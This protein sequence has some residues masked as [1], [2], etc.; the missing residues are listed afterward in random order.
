LNVTHQLLV[1]ADDVNILGGSVHTTKKNAETLVDASMETG[2]EVHA[3]RT[4]YMVMFRDQNVGRSHNLMIDN[5]SFGRMEEL[6]YLGT[7]L[8]NQYCIQENI[9]SRFKSGNACCHL[10]QDLLS[11]SLLSKNLK[12][13]IYRAIILPV[14]FNGRETW[15]LTLREESRLR[16]LRRIFGPKR[17]EVTTITSKYLPVLTQYCWGDKLRRMKCEEHVAR[18]GKRYGYTGFWWGNLRER[19]HMGGPGVDGRIILRRIF[20][21]WDV[22]VWTGSSCL[23]VGTGGGHLLMR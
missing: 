17:E 2:L 12:I 4:T 1:Y 16:V 14:V 3:D 5:G 22:G 8:T 6:K 11:S 19:D 9:T 7:T 13:K 20:R 18:M 10:V 21:K 23:R 15:S